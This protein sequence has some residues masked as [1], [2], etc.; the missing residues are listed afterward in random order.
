MVISGHTNHL[1]LS[2]RVFMVVQ[3]MDSNQVFHHAYQKSAKAR[4]L[5][6]GGFSVQF[7]PQVYLCS[8]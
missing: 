7:V 6:G 5:L 4:G 1:D 3:V 2:M 8:E